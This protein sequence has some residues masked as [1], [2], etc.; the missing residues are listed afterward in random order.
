MQNIQTFLFK[1]YV[2]ETKKE[3]GNCNV[4]DV[5]DPKIVSSLILAGIVHILNKHD[6][7]AA[8]ETRKEIIFIED[9]TRHVGVENW[10]TKQ[11]KL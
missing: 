3:S 1:N 7:I 11:E 9:V 10:I 5:F 2:R 4:F 6:T 8:L